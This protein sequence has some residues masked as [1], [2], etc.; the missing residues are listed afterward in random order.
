LFN[1]RLKKK[2]NLC[3]VCENSEAV[4]FKLLHQIPSNFQFYE[5]E[6]LENQVLGQTQSNNTGQH[7]FP[8]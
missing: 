8:P 3:C 1:F 2:R 4:Q 7:Q 5:A 6:T